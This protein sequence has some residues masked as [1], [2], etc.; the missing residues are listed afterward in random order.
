PLLR[1]AALI[2]EGNHWP[3]RSA[4]AARFSGRLS[5]FVSKRPIWLAEAAEPVIARSPTQLAAH[6]ASS[7]VVP[8]AALFGTRNRD[9]W[10]TGLTILTT[11]GQLL[12]L[13]EATKRAMRKS[14]VLVV[15]IANAGGEK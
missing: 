4:R 8:Q 2:V 1:C 15:P 13:A 12:P 3:G 7:D 14:S 10:D 6:Q 5:H 9:G 11:P